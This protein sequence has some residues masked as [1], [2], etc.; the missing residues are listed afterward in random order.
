MN[1]KKI[2]LYALGYLISYRKELAKSLV[3]PFVAIFVKDLPE[4]NGTGFY[5][6]ILLSSIMSVLLYT[7]VAI[8]THRVILLG[9][10]HIAKW[11]IYIP[12]WREAYFVLYS[13]G[14]ALLI[15]LMSLISFLPIIG[16]VL[17]IVFII[18]IMARLSLV[19]PAIATDHKWSFSDSWNAT[20]DHQLLMVLVVGIFPFFLTIPGIVLSYIPYANWLNTLVSL[21]TTV[22]VVAVLS[23][24]F[25][26]IT[27]EE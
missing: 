24:A 16:G 20:Q 25:K 13:I 21:F 18:Y 19:F 15:A 17:T 11:G 26:E 6:N 9:P 5:F 8:T 27:Q 23:V 2:V 12:T 14:L 22:F 3:I 7:F 1:I 4:I 10:N